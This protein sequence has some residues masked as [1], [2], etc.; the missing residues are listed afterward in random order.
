MGK[1]LD[2]LAAAC[3]IPADNLKASVEKYNGFARKGV[4]EEFG[5]G[6]NRYDKWLGDHTNR[7]N[8]TLGTVEKGP[9]YAVAVYPGDVGTFGGVVTDE[10]A[11]VIM[12]DGSV[13][14][15]LYACG[16]TSA[17]VMGRTYPGAGCSIGP[18]FT[19]GYI[20]AKH[21]ANLDNVG[22]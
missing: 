6:R 21:A 12:E 19:F 1:T 9:F 11:R 22:V 3:D 7:P 14:G 20:A 17:A 13:L 2:D 16:T 15:G 10:H 4:D 8:A 5:R 18:S